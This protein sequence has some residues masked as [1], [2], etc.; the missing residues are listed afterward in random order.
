MIMDQLCSDP[1]KSSWWLGCLR[2]LE[3]YYLI[4]NNRPSCIHGHQNYFYQTVKSKLP[5]RRS[6]D[7][8]CF[9]FSAF[10]SILPQHTTPPYLSYNN[11]P[12]PQKVEFWSSYNSES[13]KLVIIF[14]IIS[15]VK[16]IIYCS[17]LCL[18]QLILSLNFHLA[19]RC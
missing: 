5:S 12:F 1:I 11:N 13:H 4:L 15:E 7:H 10:V 14:H 19:C 6:C 8:A 16:Q 18:N 17:E 3:K 9:F 2:Q